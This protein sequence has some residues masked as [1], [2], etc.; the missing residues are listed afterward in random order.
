[1]NE[2]ETRDSAD[3]SAPDNP[4][5]AVITAFVSGHIDLTEAEFAS[6][7]KPRIDAAFARGHRFVVGDAAGCDAMA[8]S[9]LS[10][11]MAGRQGGPVR[12]VVVY[13][14]MICPRNNRDFPTVGGYMSDKARDSAMTA[15]STYD[16]AWVRQ[17]REKSGTAKNLRRR[18]ASDVPR[19]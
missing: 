14:M 11:L 6:H 1:M 8:Q 3:E 17:G 16:I 4:D 5:N 19:V 13:H 7:Y 15:A 2:E 10:L 18:Q 9:N 12:R